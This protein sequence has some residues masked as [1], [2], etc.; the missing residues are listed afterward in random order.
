MDTPIITDRIYISG[1]ISGLTRE[2]YTERFDSAEQLLREAGYVNIV[3]PTKLLP[4]RFPWLYKLLGY[5][6]TLLYDLW[7]LTGCQRIYKLPDWRKSR[8]AQIESCVAYHF[9][10]YT[11]ARPI[12]DV[13]DEKMTELIKSRE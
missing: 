11:L 7:K 9:S 10:I 6:L 8:G 1:P 12:R 3:N 13:I 2:Q 5:R 4:A